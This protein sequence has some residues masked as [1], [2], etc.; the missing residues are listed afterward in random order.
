MITKDRYREYERRNGFLSHNHISICD[1]A[2]DSVTVKVELS[3]DSM[4]F[5]GSVHGGLRYTLCDCAAGLLARA[6]DRDY[7]TQSV[8]MNYLRN[9]RGGVVYG[10]AS[11][12]NRGKKVTI[13]RVDAVSEDGRLLAQATADMFCT[14]DHMDF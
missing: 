5:G 8:H 6:D 2:M 13:I 1:V 4:N 3:K 7:V 11:V 12:V 10:K 9:V 14:S